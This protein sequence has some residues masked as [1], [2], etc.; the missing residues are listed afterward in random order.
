MTRPVR[1]PSRSSAGRRL[2][3]A[4]VGAALVAGS[5]RGLAHPRVQGVDVAIGDAVRR[6]DHAVVDDVAVGTT[7]LGSVYA[8]VG[9]AAVLAGAGRRRAGGDVLALG[10][11]GWCVAQVSKRRVSRARPYE[12]HGVRRLI[13]QPRGSSFP[14]GHAA[15]AMAVMSAVAQHSGGRLGRVLA[16]GVG[17]YVGL[18]RV[19]VGVHYPTDVIGGAG[20]GLLLET[21]WGGPVARVGRLLT[22]PAAGLVGRLLPA[23]ARVAAVIFLA[24][25]AARALRGGAPAEEF[26]VT[27]AADPTQVLAGP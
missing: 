25:R 21:L 3:R 23:E 10:L 18:T 2:R 27:E 22:Q 4:A 17:A 8:A 11:L 15:L 24:G 6:V 19:H 9:I 5:W 12:A 16:Y 1:A 26:A 14:S 20:L 13:R 7:D